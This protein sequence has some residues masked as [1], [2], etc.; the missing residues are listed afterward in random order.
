MEVGVGEVHAWGCAIWR[1]G[2]LHQLYWQVQRLLERIVLGNLGV[3]SRR[4]ALF[5]SFSRHSL[6]EARV[7]PHQDG[8]AY[9]SLAMVVVTLWIDEEEKP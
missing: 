5:R 8:E 9:R 4:L 1:K 7:R 3:C 6:S 2:V